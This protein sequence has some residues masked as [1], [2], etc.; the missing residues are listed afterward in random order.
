MAG[1]TSDPRAVSSTPW[2][3][4]D[5]AEVVRLHALI[6]PTMGTPKPGCV[7]GALGAAVNAALYKADDE[8]DADLACIAGCALRYLAQNQ[9]FVDGNK[10]IAWSVLVRTFD[11]NGMRV[12][13]SEQEAAQVTLDV[14]EKKRSMSPTSK[15]GC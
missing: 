15:R 4:P 11:L 13:A 9:C 12:E 8:A 7:E 3:L 5:A 1:D 2:A 6:A 14:A 10:R